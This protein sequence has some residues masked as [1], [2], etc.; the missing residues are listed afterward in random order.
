MAKKDTEEIIEDEELEL[1]DE[2]DDDE[3]YTP[4]KPDRRKQVVTGNH[5]GYMMTPTMI[6]AGRVATKPNLGRV[7]EKY[8]FDV[9]EEDYY[10]DR[11]ALN[12]DSF[13]S[14]DTKQVT[15]QIIRSIDYQGLSSDQIKLIQNTIQNTLQ[16]Y[17]IKPDPEQYTV[18]D[19]NMEVLEEFLSAKRIENKA[20]ST[21]YNYGKEMTK[22]FQFL[23]KPFDQITSEDIRKYMDFRKVHDN[24]SDC[25]L[26]N[27]RMYFL[28]FFK[29]CSQEEKIKKNPMDKIGVVKIN[30]KVV[31]FLTDEELEMIRCACTCERDLAIVDVLSGSGMRV[32]ELT[33]L[34]RSDVD[35]E[36]GEMKVFGKGGKE[37]ICYLTG[38]AKVHLKWYLESRTDDNPALFVATKKP[39]GRL[40]R[41]SIEYILKNISMNSAIPEVK[42]NPHKFRKT[43]A[44]QMVNKGAD[45]TYVQQLLGHSSSDTTIS[46]Y[47]NFSNDTVKSAHHKYVN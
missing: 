42:L 2:D 8:K 32:S 47:T 23:N 45:I 18:L 44:T 46:C 15:D 14:A 4:K 13:K 37:R 31:E 33:G 24:V 10:D 1:I 27:I 7:E 17:D 16:G 35:L 19:K 22:L 6:A 30:K 39:Y 28:A 11:N 43:L 25:T 36:R 41:H 34:N 3:D 9:K 40:T 20:A 26:H 12:K 29:Y 5:V 38:R 21:L